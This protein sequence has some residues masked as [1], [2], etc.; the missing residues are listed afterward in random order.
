MRTTL[1]MRY[2]NG[3]RIDMQAAIGLRVRGGSR[4]IGKFLPGWSGGSL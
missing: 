4:D 3:L 2:N 1:M